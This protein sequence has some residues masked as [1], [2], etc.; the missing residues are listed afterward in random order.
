MTLASIDWIQ[1]LEPL[2]FSTMWGVYQFSGLFV[3]GLAAI[4]IIAGWLDSA[5]HRLLNK[6]HLHDMAKLLFA[7]STFWMYIWF[8]QAMLI[9]Y[10]NIS[11]E[12]T[13]YADR[14]RLGWGPVMIA[15]VLL[16]WII[17]FFVLMPLRAKR[18]YTIVRRVGIV[19]LIG[20]AVDLLVQ[21]QPP[22]TGSAPSLAWGEAGALLLI[23]ATFF[24]VVRRRFNRGTMVPS[25]DPYLKES[26]HYHS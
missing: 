3:A 25:G 16:N 6:N 8:S 11:E 15:V 26:Y 2:W 23:A 5:G 24:M 9:W 21:I 19:V 10:A 18:N 17:P 20:H 7:M 14:L 13:H 1:S 4:V 12:A 22:V